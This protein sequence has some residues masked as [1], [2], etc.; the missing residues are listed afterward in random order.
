MNS[1][2]M[3]TGEDP[4]QGRRRTI[5]ANAD[6]RM[7]TLAWLSVGLLAGVVACSGTSNER[8]TDRDGAT[9]VDV[10]LANPDSPSGREDGTPNAT[11]DSPVDAAETDAAGF[12]ARQT[13]DTAAPIPDSL[14]AMDNGAQDA[15]VIAEVSDGSP[16]LVAKDIAEPEAEAPR[17]TEATG[18]DSLL[19]KDAIAA[20][21]LRPSDTLDAKVDSAPMNP[22]SD[23]GIP[24]YTTTRAGTGPCE[25][26]AVGTLIDEINASGATLPV[27]R[28]YTGI[29]AT[30]GSYVYAFVRSDGGFSFAVKYGS[31]DCPSG[32]IE[33]EYW[34][35]QTDGGCV[36]QQVGHY[37]QQ[38][39]WACGTPLWNVPANPLTP[40]TKTCP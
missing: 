6:V 10:L 40:T 31:G 2:P 23:P 3:S 4:K 12:D 34:Y 8:G 16:D 22:V 29:V 25:G 17:D 36:P 21:S 35:F 7:A 11:A 20:D 9:R 38:S 18:L 1:H 33:N 14:L 37:R 30:D 24:V 32:C 19:T 28:L 27:T 13:P 5:A 26:K 39:G 15:Q